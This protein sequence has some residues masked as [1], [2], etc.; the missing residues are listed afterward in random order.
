[1]MKI[2]PPVIKALSIGFIAALTWVFGGDFVAAF[3]AS[4]GAYVPAA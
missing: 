2:T 1:M 4:L 3:I